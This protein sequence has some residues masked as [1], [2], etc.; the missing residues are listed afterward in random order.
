MWEQGK[1]PPETSL[2][3]QLSKQLHALA[4]KPESGF[5]GSGFGLSNASVTRS[6][7]G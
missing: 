7:A 2:G 6:A 3:L 1:I 4:I 5:C